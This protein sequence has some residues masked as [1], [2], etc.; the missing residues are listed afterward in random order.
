[1]IRSISFIILVLCSLLFPWWVY[2]VMIVPYV[3]LYRG[4]EVLLVGVG[5]DALF[6]DPVHHGWY[7][8]T[9]LSSALL[10][11]ATMVK[12]YLMSYTHTHL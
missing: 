6:Y 7:F 11:I 3:L 5:I 10:I 1:M 9:L 8:Y 12:P 2:M 4:W